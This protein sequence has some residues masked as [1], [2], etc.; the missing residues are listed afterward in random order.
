[1]F[2]LSVVLAVGF[3]ALLMPAE[4]RQQEVFR[5][6]H[7]RISLLWDGGSECGLVLP[8]LWESFCFRDGV[9]L[10]SE[11]SADLE[12]RWRDKQVQWLLPPTLRAFW[13]SV[14][15]KKA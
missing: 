13:D 10:T 9:V 12:N 1:M 7:P 6:R 15:R 8:I 2:A 4:N 3:W 14:N 11:C 5:E